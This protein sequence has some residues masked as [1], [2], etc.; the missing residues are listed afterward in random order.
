MAGHPPRQKSNLEQDRQIPSFPF[1]CLSR[2]RM[3]FP[4]TIS[5][6]PVRKTVPRTMPNR[7][8]A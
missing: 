2:L 4:E 6:S 7:L 3:G 8:Q 1:T 5:P